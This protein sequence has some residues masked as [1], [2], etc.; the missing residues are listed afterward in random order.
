M[1]I[2]SI[3]SG[4]FCKILLLQFSHKHFD[5]KES[6]DQSSVLIRVVFIIIYIFCVFFTQVL[7]GEDFSQKQHR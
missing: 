7:N 5:G 4:R 1:F 2:K 6:N 3:Q